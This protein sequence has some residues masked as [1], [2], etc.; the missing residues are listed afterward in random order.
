MSLVSF[1]NSERNYKAP[2]FAWILKYF[3]VFNLLSA[4]DPY[5]VLRMGIVLW[6]EPPN[7]PI[8]NVSAVLRATYPPWF[9][10]PILPVV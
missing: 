4:V 7:K 10:T 9:S 5:V 8:A 2:K 3:I 1:H 6:A